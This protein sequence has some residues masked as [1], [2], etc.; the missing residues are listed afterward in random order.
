M[1]DHVMPSA[2]GTAPE[3]QCCSRCNMSYQQFM[4]NGKPRCPGRP[5]TN[6]DLWPDIRVKYHPADTEWMYWGHQAFEQGTLGEPAGDTV[7]VWEQFVVRAAILR[8]A[9]I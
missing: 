2:S 8:P 4:D 3:Q 1:S 5:Y 6:A 9:T 7:E